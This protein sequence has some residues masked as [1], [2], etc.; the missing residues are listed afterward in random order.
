VRDLG[1]P[2]SHPF[3]GLAER[4][5]NDPALRPA[6]EPDSLGDHFSLRNLN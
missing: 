4:D 1:E 5:Q 2:E 6:E 3:G